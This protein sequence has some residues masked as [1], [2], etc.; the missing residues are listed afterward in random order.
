[1]VERTPT[2]IANIVT[3]RY[4]E[5]VDRLHGWFR[6]MLTAWNEP[7]F[8]FARWTLTTEIPHM[9]G[10][11]VETPHCVV[12]VHSSCDDPSAR[13][14]FPDSVGARQ[15][16]VWITSSGMR[17]RSFDDLAWK[18]LSRSE[19]EGWAR[20]VLGPEWSNSA[21]RVHAQRNERGRWPV[22]FVVFVDRNGRPLTA[23]DDFDWGQAGVGS[24]AR[25]MDLSTS[26]G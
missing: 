22:L 7:G 2:E 3:E 23:P 4:A 13:G 12:T 24:P 1:M 6:R 9:S 25:P 18:P 16:S 21:Y 11:S 5:D 10:R 15:L 26:D 20:A 17:V 14:S 8:D 19:S